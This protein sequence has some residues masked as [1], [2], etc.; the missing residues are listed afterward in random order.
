MSRKPVSIDTGFLKIIGIVLMDAAK[1]PDFSVAI[2][3]GGQSRRMGRNK[4][5]LEVDG[6]H[7]LQR[8]IDAVRNLTD[9]L[10]LVT[11]TPEVYQ[12]FGLRM[13]GDVMPGKAALGGIYTALLKAQYEWVFLLACDMPRLD[14]KVITFLADLRVG[15]DIVTPQVEA[16]PETLHTFYRKSCES[17]I[18]PRLAADELRVTGFFSEARV[19]YVDRAALGQVSDDFDFLVNLNTP[20]DLADLGQS[21]P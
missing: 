14:P 8:V 21:G 20:A 1:Q 6:T 19:R 10:F 15:V 16:H 9:D 18:K 3:V 7:L 17:L 4:A 2:L 5:L 13:V 11:N 12:P